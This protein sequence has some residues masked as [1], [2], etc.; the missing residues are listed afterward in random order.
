MTRWLLVLLVACGPGV[1]RRDTRMIGREALAGAGA[2]RLEE[3]MRDEVTNGGIWFDDAE[4][5]KQFGVAGPVLRAEVP[6]FA[7]CVAKLGMTASKRESALGDVVIM[8]YA[9]GIELEVRVVQSNQ[10]PWLTWIGYATRTSGDLDVPTITKDALE[11]LRLAGDPN[12]P[13]DPTVASELVEKADGA[14][15]WI[16]VCIDS[17]GAVTR[18]ESY[19]TTSDKAGTAFA[20][21]AAQWKFRPFV[22]RGKPMAACSLARMVFPPGKAEPIETLP[23]PPPPSQS[24][25]RPIVLA[26]GSKLLEGKRI[27]G[28]RAIIPDDMTRQAMAEAMVSKV[29]GT[30]RICLDET[31]HPESVMPM[32][33]TTFAEY[34][35]KILAAM[36]Q[37]VYSP[38]QIDDVPVPVCTTVTFIYTQ[39][40]GPTIRR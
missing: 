17:T 2:D 32:R 40:A 35:A 23:M 36:R 6:A 21:A 4:C 5:A 28:E 34:D 22:T 3:L 16:K 37:W 13:L 10:G 20:A 24:K 8:E 12:G 38:Y 14:F 31:G 15:S 7:K 1:Q 27:A 11:R 29:V 26:K 19:E 33:S 30:F 25:K 39:N 18:T 9:P